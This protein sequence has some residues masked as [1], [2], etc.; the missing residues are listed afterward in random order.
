[1][2]SK[3]RS[4][5]NE[6]SLYHAYCYCVSVMP[7][8]IRKSCVSCKKTVDNGLSY[9][10]S[11]NLFRFFSVLSLERTGPTGLACSK[12]HSKFDNWL[13]KNKDFSWSLVLKSSQ[14]V[15]GWI[16]GVILFKV[17]SFVLVSVDSRC[18]FSD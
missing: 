10:C 3:V 1:M 18:N 5:I 16:L 12:S 7:R 11:K 14:V 15:N 4:V 9:G 13:C 6:I 8:N 2:T 17:L